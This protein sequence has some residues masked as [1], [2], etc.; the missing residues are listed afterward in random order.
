MSDTA[1]YFA[2]IAFHVGTKSTSSVLHN[3]ILTTSNATSGVLHQQLLYHAAPHL[4]IRLVLVFA[5]V[6]KVAVRP[7]VS[8]SDARASDR[9]WTF[10]LYNSDYSNVENIMFGKFNILPGCR[11]SSAKIGSSGHSDA[12]NTPTTVCGRARMRM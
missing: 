12:C 9:R 7:S 3:N 2:L 10:E 8:L 6:R 4:Y 1:I 5:G 11:L